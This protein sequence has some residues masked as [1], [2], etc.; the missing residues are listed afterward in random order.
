MWVEENRD[1]DV[2][3]EE[4]HFCFIWAVLGR[5]R[6][7]GKDTDI[8]DDQPESLGILQQFLGKGFLDW[9]AVGIG[10]K[11]GATEPALMT[12]AWLK[13]HPTHLHASCQDGT[14]PEL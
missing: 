10:D 14:E 4:S 12:W 5:L 9:L 2:L 7:L 13:E 1:W 3:G 11:G 8:R 6:A